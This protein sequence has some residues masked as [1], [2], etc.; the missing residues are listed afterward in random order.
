MP[1]VGP[2]WKRRGIIHRKSAKAGT[3][4]KN[5]D[6]GGRKVSGM[7]IPGRHQFWNEGGRKGPGRPG[8]WG[9][10]GEEQRK[11]REGHTGERREESTC[12]ERSAPMGTSRKESAEQE[13]RKMG[14]R[15]LILWMLLLF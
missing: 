13:P 8:W 4:R 7:M 9:A 3:K 5:E 11:G 1:G 14:T 12:W 15:V 10:E 6:R 2:G